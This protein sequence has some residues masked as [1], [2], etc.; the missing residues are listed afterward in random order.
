VNLS[1]K[2]KAKKEKAAFDAR[3]DHEVGEFWY[4][5]NMDANE[6]EGGH[7][8]CIPISDHRNAEKPK[9]KEAE[10][11]LAVRSVGVAPPKPKNGAGFWGWHGKWFSGEFALT[12]TR[13]DDGY[14]IADD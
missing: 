9:E 12:P 6:E 13:P 1:E 2:E 3:Q 11:K 10:Q 8:S 7:W 14:E 4:M 5:W